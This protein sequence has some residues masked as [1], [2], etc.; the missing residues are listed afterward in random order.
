MTEQ[1]RPAAGFVLL[2]STAVAGVRSVLVAA[3]GNLAVQMADGSDNNANPVPV[4]AG[5]T[6]PIKAVKTMGA[7]TATLLGLL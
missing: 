6:I 7:N 1:I 2:S 5:Q 4:T 3:S